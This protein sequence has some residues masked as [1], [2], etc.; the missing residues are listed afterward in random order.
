[1]R[2]PYADM[3]AFMVELRKQSGMGARA[4]EFAILTS[5]RSG[6][7]RGATWGEVDRALALWVIPAGRMKAEK[8]HRVP[9]SSGAIALLRKLPSLGDVVFPGA[10]EG[11]PLS[12]V[13]LTAVL[14]RMGRGDIT[15]HAFRSTFRDWCSES[16]NFP[17]EVCEHA[18][19]HSLPDKVEAAYRRGDLIE[20]RTMPM[21]NWSDF[22]ATTASA[23]SLTPVRGKA[24]A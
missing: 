16:T 10:R 20:K 13:S 14:R 9:L 8:E 6:E 12:D 24:T 21:Q 2:L 11:K 19:A 18:L 1:L 22:C 17:R 4:V 23:N 7:V 3:P 15:V 5:A